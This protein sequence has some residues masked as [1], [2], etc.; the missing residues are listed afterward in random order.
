M[1]LD[2]RC[3]FCSSSEKRIIHMLTLSLRQPYASLII[4]G[5]KKFETRSWRPGERNRRILERDGLLIH[6]GQNKKSAPLMGMPPFSNYLSQIGTMQYGFII[7][8]C[9]VG[10]IIRTEEWLKE[11]QPR[12]GSP[13]FEEWAFG[14][15]H[16]GRYA[17]EIIEPEVF[18]TPIP[19]RGKLS[20]F[21]YPFT[22]EEI[23]DRDRREYGEPYD[24]EIWAS[25]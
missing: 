20:L 5:L 4:H 25:G 7:G 16:P 6:A 1:S 21:D 11:F 12:P 10:R 19:C 14:D 2:Q 23:R 22:P 18:A 15:F 24:M 3:R 17:W 13:W 8:R 9:R